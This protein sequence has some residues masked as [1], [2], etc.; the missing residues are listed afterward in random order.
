MALDI[1]LMN[2]MSW[3]DL[4]LR[5]AAAHP[6][7]NCG[8]DPIPSKRSQKQENHAIIN[9]VVDELRMIE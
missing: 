7:K 3:E 2:V 9:N 1:I 8:I 4:K 5:Y 6:T